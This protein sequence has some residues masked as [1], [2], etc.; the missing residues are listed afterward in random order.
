[1]SHPLGPAASL[2]LGNACLPCDWAALLSD[3]DHFTAL[4]PD[5]PQPTRSRIQKLYEE[6]SIA[7]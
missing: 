2:V 1:M 6:T 3:Y 7:A 4:I 5:G